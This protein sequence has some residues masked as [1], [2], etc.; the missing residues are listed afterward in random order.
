MA[1]PKSKPSA[2]ASAALKEQDKSPVSAAEF[3]LADF[4]VSKVIAERFRAPEDARKGTYRLTAST[5][6]LVF[7]EP[8][9]VPQMGV[10]TFTLNVDGSTMSDDD[11]PS[12]VKSF[13]VH[14]ESEGR[15]EI[16]GDVDT[17]DR[18][19]CEGLVEPIISLMHALCV[20]TAR[21]EADS[22]GYRS[23][24]PSYQPKNRPK[25]KIHPEESNAD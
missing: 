13:S 18:T 25:P 1:R 21:T 10:I 11:P 23:V 14:I 12:K 5:G 16:V 15:F 19:Q 9:T 20:N 6:D 7:S 3:I 2:N 22:M 4:R 17:E 24:R 8:N